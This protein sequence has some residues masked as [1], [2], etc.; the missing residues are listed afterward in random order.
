MTKEISNLV[1]QLQSWCETHR[2]KQVELASMLGVTPA[3]VTEWFKG[4]NH[5]KGE[6]IVRIMEMVKHKPPAG[7]SRKPK[8]R[9]QKP[10]PAS[11][12]P[13]DNGGAEDMEFRQ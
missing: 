12:S 6:L 11:H 5:P 1:L 4:R 2:V 13:E 7:R 10:K 3:A 9:K 8:E